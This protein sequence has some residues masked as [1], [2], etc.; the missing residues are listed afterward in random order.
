MLDFVGTDST[1]DLS[2]A[3]LRADRE[4]VVVGSAGGRLSV[5][6]PGP[7]PHGTRISLPFSGTRSELT[8]VIPLDRFG[9]PEAPGGRPAPVPP[10][11]AHLQHDL[12][13][14]TIEPG[15]VTV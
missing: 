11:A 4:L 13:T 3:S 6:K 14:T 7:L 8:E 2:A 5:R 1:L 15:E 12:D 10:G 9:A